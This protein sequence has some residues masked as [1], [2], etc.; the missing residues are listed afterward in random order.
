MQWYL[1]R[2]PQQRG[3]SAYCTTARPRPVVCE[4][5]RSSSKS[6]CSSTGRLALGEPWFEWYDERS[7]PCSSALITPR[8]MLAEPAWPSGRRSALGRLE[9]AEARSR[10]GMLRLSTLLALVFTGVHANTHS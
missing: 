4:S 3:R 10:M 7:S 8:S 6:Y 2:W 1:R 5:L 9:L